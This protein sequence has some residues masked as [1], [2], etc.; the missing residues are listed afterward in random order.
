MI[1]KIVNFDTLKQRIKTWQ[2]EGK[3]VVLCYGVFNMLHVGHIRYLKQA[4]Q[5]G[6]KLV[7]VLNPESDLNDI[8]LQEHNAFRSEALAYL[9][10]GD[11]VSVNKY[12]NYR[13]MIK[14]LMPNL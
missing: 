3:T 2:S 5:Q 12:T 7:V 8:Q 11:A 9:D 14:I 6:E 10:W 4:A 1:N 13:E